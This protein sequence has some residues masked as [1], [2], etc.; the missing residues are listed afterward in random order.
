MRRSSLK[1]Q[2]QDRAI[3]KALEEFREDQPWCWL[4][5]GRRATDVDE[6]ARGGCRGVARY[7]RRCWFRVCNGCHLTADVMVISSPTTLCIKLALKQMFDEPFYDL[8]AVL[9]AKM[10]PA[11]SQ[12]VTEEEVAAELAVLEADPGIMRALAKTRGDH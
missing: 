7:D 2:R 11:T 4:G 12:Y 9:D 1:R 10:L 8:R 6:M 5:C 3:A